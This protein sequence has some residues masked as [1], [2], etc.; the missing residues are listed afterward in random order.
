M[1]TYPWSCFMLGKKLRLWNSCSGSGG[2]YEL[3]PDVGGKAASAFCMISSSTFDVASSQ[4]VGISDASTGM[5]FCIYSNALWL[6]LSLMLMVER[7]VFT[8]RISSSL[9]PWSSAIAGVLYAMFFSSRW[10]LAGAENINWMGVCS[11]INELTKTRLLASFR[12]CTMSVENSD[13]DNGDVACAYLISSFLAFWLLTTTLWW[14]E[15]PAILGRSLSSDG[16][17]KAFR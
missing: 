16:S 1:S 5:T 7:Y 11:C 12:S 17:S 8:M 10:W 9:A 3:E 15:L 2:G 6:L 13:G 14:W 4:F